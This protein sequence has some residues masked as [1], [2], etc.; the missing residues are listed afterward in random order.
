MVRDGQRPVIAEN[1]HVVLAEALGQ[2]LLLVQSDVEA[3][4]LVIRHAIVE[5]HRA[6]GQRHKAL[7]ETGDRHAGP[8]MRVQDAFRIR[9]RRMDCAVNH[10]PCPI[11]AMHGIT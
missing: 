2:A 3:F 7:F 1:Q 5:L 11:H 4:E 9:T 10:E 8:A 6:L